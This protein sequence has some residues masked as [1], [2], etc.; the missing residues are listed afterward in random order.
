M[1]DNWDFY[2][3][4]VNDKP[5]SIFVDLDI[6]K[7][8]PLA[9]FPYMVN[10]LV[11]VKAPRPD[12]FPGA[13]EYDALSALEDALSSAL[14]SDK[15]ALYV[16][17]NTSDG[18]RDFFFFTGDL[19][20]VKSRVAQ[21]TAGFPAYKVDWGAG[22][23]PEWKTYFEFLYPSAE[24]RQRM[25]NRRMCERLKEAG[26]SLTQARDIDHFAVFPT[27]SARTAFAEKITEMGFRVSELYDREN[28]THR[29]GI[30]FIRS[31]VPSHGGMDDI[32]LPLL[33]IARTLG[34]RYGGWGATVER[35]TPPS[36]L[37][38]ETS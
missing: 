37:S 8:A 12:G 22:E 24:D 18:R 21:A 11:P 13:D 10:V 35:D 33:D 1:S 4:R 25:E 28:T 26:D 23:D 36:L 20:G 9:D 17:R 27:A 30:E 32:T 31:D 38:G 3:C 34:G 15:S 29:F 5:A 6:A 16:G 2:F 7:E 14:C 19:S